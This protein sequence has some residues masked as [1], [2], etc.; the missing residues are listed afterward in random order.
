M[1]V[2][3]IGHLRGTATLSGLRFWSEEIL[4]AA[5]PSMEWRI[6]GGF[7]LPPD[8]EWIK[9]HVTLVGHVVPPDHEFQHADVVLVPTPI[10][11]GIRVRIL[12]AMKFGCCIVAH[13][14]NAQGIPELR[15]GFNCRLGDGPEIVAALQDFARWPRIRAVY[16]ENAQR[17]HE[18]YFSLE[19]A[20]RAFVERVEA[21]MS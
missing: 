16:G 15:D 10:P 9:P 3:L 2:L 12:T 13:T 8:L 18:R 11:L 5:W 20:G 17:T 1:R 14:A 6:V 21:A 19:T 7:D 4:P